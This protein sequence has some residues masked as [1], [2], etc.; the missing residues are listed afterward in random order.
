M[1][2]ISASIDVLL[3]VTPG[4]LKGPAC[5]KLVIMP[6][7]K[8][9]ESRLTNEAITIPSLYSHERHRFCAN[10]KLCLLKFCSR[11]KRMNGRRPK[12]KNLYTTIIL[13][14]TKTC[15]N[16]PEFKLV[17]TSHVSK[18]R[19]YGRHFNSIFQTHFL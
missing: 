1:A 2:C 5:T 15:K 17:L 16:Q 4:A 14:G 12:T 13:M 9:L 8:S 18:Q 7:Y 11:S 10:C 6:V 19:F 3:L